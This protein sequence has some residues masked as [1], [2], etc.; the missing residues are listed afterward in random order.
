MIPEWQ[1][2]LI[3]ETEELFKKTNKL[4]DFTRTKEFFKLDRVRKDLLY[5]QLKHM[6]SYLQVLGKRIEVE[7]LQNMINIGGHV[8]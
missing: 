2:R 5:A 8:E 4:Q 3:T 1:A 6:T 7:N